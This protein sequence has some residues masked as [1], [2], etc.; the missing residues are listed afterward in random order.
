MKK[1]EGLEQ[2]GLTVNKKHECAY[3]MIGGYKFIVTFHPQARQ[4]TLLTTIKSDNES[5]V[6]SQYL[7][8][9]D[10]GAYINWASYSNYVMAVNVKNNKHLT[11]WDLEKMMKEIAGIAYQN[12][13]VQCC[14]HCGQETNLD[15]CTLNG[16]NDLMC[17]N[18]LSQY[19][20]NLPAPKPTNMSLGI[21]GSLIGSLIGVAVWVII[22]KMGF[23][24]GITGFIMA[25][26]CFKGYELL[27]GRI[28]QKGVWIALAIA[29]VMLAA[30]E[31]ISLGLEI[32]DVYGGY[33]D[34]HFFDAMQSVPYFLEDSDVLWAVIE[35][36]AFGYVFMAAASFS[37]VRNMY[38]TA[39]SDGVIERIG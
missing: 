18:C 27:G 2:I 30:A 14:R 11:V 33:Y 38:K 35:D 25:V 21:V 28:D 36:L 12:D 13:Y 26:C 10:K 39:S 19:S 17:A 8:T 6:L 23:I 31:M 37:Y 4:Y 16:Q 24:A 32:L 29:V 7:E 1:L 22:Y 20:M 3:G 34:I 15:V 9:M 5:G